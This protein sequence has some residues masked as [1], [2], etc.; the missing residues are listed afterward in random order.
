MIRSKL[1]YAEVIW[2]PKK[3]KHALKLKRIQKI[4]TKMVPELENITYEED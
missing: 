1:E 2:S 4:A 3:K